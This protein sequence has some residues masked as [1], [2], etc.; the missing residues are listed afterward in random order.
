M[1]DEP[2]I[3]KILKEEEKLGRLQGKSQSSYEGL[4]MIEKSSD[5]K[6]DKTICF[7]E[8]EIRR[9]ED[10]IEPEKLKEIYRTIFE[11]YAV[12]VILADKNERIISW[13]KYFTLSA[14][15]LNIFVMC[16][17]IG[18]HVSINASTR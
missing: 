13:N 16:I 7:A 15:A 3:V 17:I 6:A 5:D 1:K 4:Q 18:V 9:I 14:R 12:A 11:N 8:D 10:A 2:E